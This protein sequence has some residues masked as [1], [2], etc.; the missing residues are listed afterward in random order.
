MHYSPKPSIASHRTSSLPNPN[1]L[2][3]PSRPSGIK[4]SS[5]QNSVEMQL[6]YYN[7]QWSIEDVQSDVEV[8]Q[9]QWIGRPGWRTYAHL[10]VTVRTDGRITTWLLTACPLSN[11]PH[12]S[13]PSFGDLS[14]IVLMLGL[15]VARQPCTCKPLQ[16][17]S[18]PSSDYHEE[19]DLHCSCVEE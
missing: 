10:H 15:L 5:R 17:Y 9:D 7:K 11:S 8:Q 18:Q 16:K 2:H 12:L 13:W 14:K 6:S 19:V 4:I 3:I 1:P